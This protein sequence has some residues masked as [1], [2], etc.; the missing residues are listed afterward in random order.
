MAEHGTLTLGPRGLAVA[1][2]AAFLLALLL[3]TGLEFSRS[4]DSFRL[5]LPHV[6]AA[7]LFSGAVVLAMA[8]RERALAGHLD[9][10]AL[11]RARTASEL[12]HQTGLAQGILGG[13]PVPFL[14]VDENERA[15]FSN[16]ECLEMLE[17]DGRPEDYL[18]QTLAQIFYNDPGRKTAVGRSI[19]DGEVF[20]NLE[21]AIKGHK[22]GTRN[23]LANVFPLY[24]TDKRCIGGLCLYLDMTAL[25]QKEQ[26]ILEKNE[27]IGKT[28]LDANALCARLRDASS[29]LSESIGQTTRGSEAQKVRV[30]EI[31]MSMEQMSSAVIEVAKNASSASQG[32]D[33]ARQQAEQGERVVG[34]VI[35]AI[36]SVSERTLAM[37]E[38]LTELGVQVAGISQILNVINDIADQTNLLA[39]NAAIEAARAGDAGRGFAVVA[40]EVRK[41]AEKT[42]QATQQVAS[43]ISSVQDG[44]RRASEGMSGAV[45]AVGSSTS[46]SDSAGR[47]L[48]EI[49]RISQGSADQVRNIATASEEQSASAEEI[50]H[51][52]EQMREVSDRSAQDM[53]QASQAVEELARLADDLTE[54]ITKM[55]TC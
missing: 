8:L 15:V 22:G 41:L 13:L 54:I 14:L 43:G 45:E 35:T 19:K 47:A 3:L 34:E 11:E 33:A 51:A 25:K 7:L 12:K 6:A 4:A 44:A 55:Q 17:L 53:V 16:R 28:A 26:V 2:A 32:A 37:Q 36:R 40:D 27:S 18:G 48:H 10:A 46:L 23:V 5:G 9:S 24:D 1:A 29:R 31:G 20:R 39:L 30:G 42:V 38:R 21:V 49:L 52:V 50:A